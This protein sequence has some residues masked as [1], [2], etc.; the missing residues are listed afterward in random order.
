M[1]SMKI[2]ITIS[3]ME[4]HPHTPLVSLMSAS[5]AKTVDHGNRKTISTSKR[6]KIR[7]TI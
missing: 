1:A 7:A 6:R 3:I 2:K 5:F 4:N